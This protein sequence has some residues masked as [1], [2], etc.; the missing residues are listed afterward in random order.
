MSSMNLC[1]VSS[2]R[3]AR[4]GQGRFR[5]RCL[6]TNVYVL[7]LVLIAV[8]PTSVPRSSETEGGEALKTVT[9]LAPSDS[10]LPD[11]VAPHVLPFI[12]SPIPIQCQG[13]SRFS[14]L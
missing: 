3:R 4:K 10:P 1:S 13:V 11:R 5:L 8:S 12:R 6:A 14:I 9:L 7:S 2:G